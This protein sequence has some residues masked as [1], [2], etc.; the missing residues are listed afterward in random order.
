LLETG[1]VPAN[2]SRH[3]AGEVVAMALGDAY[4]RAVLGIVEERDGEA[5]A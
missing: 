4:Q 2:E 3:L 1:G 5:F